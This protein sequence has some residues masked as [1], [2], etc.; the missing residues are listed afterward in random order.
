MKPKISIWPSHI[1]GARTAARL[2][3]ILSAT[4][5]VGTMA[6]AFC[7]E[8]LANIDSPLQKLALHAKQS[9]PEANVAGVHGQ[10]AIINSTDRTQI[11]GR[12]DDKN[13]VLVHVHLDGRSSLD[14]ITKQLESVH[15]QVLDCNSTYRH[16]ILAAYLP[17]DQIENI[18]KIVGVRALTMEHRPGLHVGKVTSQGCAVLGT[19]V[20]NNQGLQGDGIT[21]GVLSDSFNTAQYNTS[22]PP[23]TTADQDVTTGDLPVVNVVQDF[24]VFGGPGNPGTDEGRA[25]CQIIYDEAPH[26]NLAFATAALSEVGFANNIMALRSQA[27]CDVIVDDATYFDE[28]VFSDGLVADT[29]NTVVNSKTLP[30]KPVIYISSAGNDGNNGYRDNYRNLNDEDVRTA[31]HH[32]NLNLDV[33][34]PNSPNFLDPSLTAG[35]WHNWNTNGGFEPITTVGAA[36]PTSF[37]Y[38]IVLQWD[39]LFDQDNGITTNYN[40]LV[41]D[42]DGNYLPVLSSTTNSFTI[43]QPMQAIRALSLG[44]NYQIAITKTKQTDPKAGPIPETHQLA[45]YTTLGGASN[46][47]GK[48]FNPDPPAVPNIYGHPA[49]DSAIAVAAYDFN[50]KPSPPYHP[51]LE[52][53]TS[54]GPVTIYFDQNNKRLAVPETRLKPEIAGVDGVNTTFFGAGYYNYPFALFGTSASAASVAGVVA[55]ML[56]EAG[57]PGSLNVATVKLALENSAQPRTSTPEMTQALG[58]SSAGFVSVTAVGQVYFGLNYFTVNYFGFFDDSIESLTIDGSGAGLVFDTTSSA[59]AIGNT[60]GMNASDVQVE[61][62]SNSTSKFTLKFKP[63]SFKSRNSISFTLGQ[64]VAGKFTGFTQD[65]FGAGSE[66]EDL[67]SGATFTAN[68][69]GEP[70]D[71]VHGRNVEAVRR[72]FERDRLIREAQQRFSRNRQRGAFQNGSLTFGYSPFDGFG[73]INAEAAVETVFPAPK[74]LSQQ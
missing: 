15:G 58:A 38:D 39:D 61:P 43:Q 13:R 26:C 23:A 54:P 70:E 45:L 9:M 51:Q 55:L 24:G 40:F 30:G 6:G 69:A 50:W 41:F 62:V 11:P 66:A 52:N 34:D 2:S 10:N 28:P 74:R 33:T 8:P 18:A 29:V 5:Y 31:G 73:L 36:G 42:Q 20:L 48:Y 16:G 37:L 25:I 21:V 22:S 7:A 67:A 1:R 12:F 63:G 57:G 27:G 64:D 59:F 65:Q 56:Q 60:I 17:T 4:V 19:D 32:G 53:T 68:F 71:R 14:E 47:I 72:G 49:A 44:V 46:L 3:C 35:G